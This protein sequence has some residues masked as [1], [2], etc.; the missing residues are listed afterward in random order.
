MSTRAE[1][2]AAAQRTLA[3]A[4]IAAR[5]EEIASTA[6]GEAQR[7][8]YDFAREDFDAIKSIVAETPP[9]QDPEEIKAAIEYLLGLAREEQG[10]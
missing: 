8:P 7:S 6:A 3:N 2:R 4:S 9:A 10:Q 5:D 1:K